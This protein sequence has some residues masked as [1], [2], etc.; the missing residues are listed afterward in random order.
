MKLLLV[1]SGLVHPPLTAIRQL[2]TLMRTRDPD[3]HSVGSLEALP[4]LDLSATRAIVLYI[5]HKRLSVEALSALDGFI[6]SGGGLLALHSA[7]ASFKDSQ[8]WFEL[9]GGRFAGHGRVEPLRLQPPDPPDEVFAGILA[10]TV[11]D[12]LYEHELKPGLR[13]HFSAEKDG[14]QQPMVW[15]RFHGSGRVCYACPGHTAGAFRSR[16]YRLVLL[17]GLDWV[18]G[19]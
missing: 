7:T 12:E 1:A 4:R 11:R 17:R 13:V 9:L 2:R 19:Q 15:T 18:A 16:E 10:F 3:L 5:H 14:L 6:S 8:A